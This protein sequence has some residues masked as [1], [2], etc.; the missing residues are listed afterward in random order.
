M[1]TNRFKNS[2]LVKLLIAVAVSFF[3]SIVVM[4]IVSQIILQLYNV[5]YLTK[6]IGII[7]Y[8]IIV[9]LVFSFVI[10]SFIITFLSITRNKIIY[11]QRITKSINEIANGKLGLTIEMKGNDELSQLA[12]NINSMSKEL[13][14]KFEYERQ[15]E[16]AK[17]ELITNVSHDLRS[18]L[19]SIIG[20]L[21]LLRK[22]KYSD[23]NQ[24]NEY[25]DTSYSK[26]KRLESLI[27]ELFEYTRLSSPDVNLN[28]NEVNLVSLLGQFIGEY[29]PI[30]EKEK[31]TI[32][33]VLPDEEIP[34]VMDVEKMVRVYENL[35]MNAIKY[36]IKPSVLH[37]HLEIL[38]SMAVLKILN[39]V[40]APPVHDMNKLFERFFIGDKARRNN[41]GTGLGLAISKKIV[42]LHGG[43]IR[44]EYDE[45]W[46]TFIVEHPIK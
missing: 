31:L 32:V 1:K 22:G 17:N 38:G 41:Q 16:M 10:L 21:D 4:V 46:I 35:L 11:I 30:F 45:G 37:I 25:L 19:T 42:E 14:N 34:I 39:Q 43:I 26:S 20:Y 33:K 6:D 5:K 27:D 36:S 7:S 24:L 44:A 29:V 13:E 18:P 23:Q 3:V 8:N 2:L 40:E 9:F 12:H 15:L 28:F